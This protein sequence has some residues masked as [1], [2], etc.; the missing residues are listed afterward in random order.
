MALARSLEPKY[1]N[2][3]IQTKKVP[4]YKSY[5]RPQRKEREIYIV[6]FPRMHRISALINTKH[7]PYKR[8]MGDIYSVFST[9]A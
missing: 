1:F 7:H 9:H 8:K 2:Q 3:K 4:D 6:F 5:R